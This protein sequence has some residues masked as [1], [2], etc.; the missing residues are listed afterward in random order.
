MNRA[1]TVPVESLTPEEIHRCASEALA[2]YPLEGPSLCFLG[3][4]DNLTFRV[5]TPD[6]ALYLL[7]LHR[8]LLPSWRGIRQK[9]EA[10]AAELAWLEALAGGG[11]TVQAPLRTRAG[12]LVALLETGR[13]A[14]GDPTEKV[15]ALPATLLTWLAGEHFSPAAESAP[16]LVEQYGRLVARLHNFSA[17]WHAPRGMARPVYEYNHFKRILSRLLR[18]TDRDIFPDA[19]YR[20]LRATHRKILE[21]ISSLPDD[22]QHWGMIHADL[23]VG[24]F[25]VHA[26]QVIPIDFSFCGFGH[27]LFDLSVCLA[28]GLRKDLRPAF[29]AG[30]RSARALPDE[31][32]AAVEAYALAGRLSYYA[33][34]IDNPA[35][36]EWLRRRLPEV[37]RN[38]CRRYLDGEPV[39][40]AL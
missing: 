33:Y 19:V 29:L 10:I 24:N 22:P 12:A 8:P 39:L 18:G 28:G 1:V 31:D 21:Q 36:R 38:E 3:H 37:T 9:P 2:L 35:E 20:T 15:P 27:Y 25:L 17:E 23:H 14:A 11:F 34:Q 6:G 7:R 26:G 13:C 16:G 32:L 30:Y 4:S 40:W 5:E